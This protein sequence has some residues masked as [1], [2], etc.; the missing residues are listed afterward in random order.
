MDLNP[1][2]MIASLNG[3]KSFLRFCTKDDF[4]RINATHIWER[5]FPG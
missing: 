5:R 3:P 1:D 2:D 4:E